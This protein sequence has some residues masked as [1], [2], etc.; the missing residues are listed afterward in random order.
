MFASHS[1]VSNHFWNIFKVCRGLQK[2]SQEDLTYFDLILFETK[3]LIQ[4]PEIEK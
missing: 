1:D 4:K 2:I 3:L